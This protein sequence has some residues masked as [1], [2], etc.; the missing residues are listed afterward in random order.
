MFVKQF[1]DYTDDDDGDDVDDG[2]E[3]IIKTKNTTNKIQLYQY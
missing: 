1:A 2:E 3:N